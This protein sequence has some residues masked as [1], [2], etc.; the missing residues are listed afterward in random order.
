[1]TITVKIKNIYGNETV[2][3]V[4]D[5]AQT[6][7]KMLNTKTLTREAL[8]HI[9]ALGYSIQVEAPTL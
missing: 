6:F 3:P 4:C 1:M 2:Y 8:K 7:A 9:K 5:T